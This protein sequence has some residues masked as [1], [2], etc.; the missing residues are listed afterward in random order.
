MTGLAARL[1]RP[2]PTARLRLTLLYGG[3]FTVAGAALLGFTYWLFER[4]TNDGKRILP[5]PA[6]GTRHRVP[7]H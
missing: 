6:A 1:P 4:G 7:A 5:T 3:L 2:R